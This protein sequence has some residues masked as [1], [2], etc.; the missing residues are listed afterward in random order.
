MLSIIIRFL[1]VVFLVWVFGRLLGMFLG[2]AKAKRQAGGRESA[3]NHMVKDPVC[4]MYMD[5]RLALRLERKHEEFFFCSEDC[6]NKYLK[7]PPGASNSA[8]PG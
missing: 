2:N 5:S 6:K 3:P 1:S 7:Q 4:G 8:P